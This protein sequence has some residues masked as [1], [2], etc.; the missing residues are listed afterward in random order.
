MAAGVFVSTFVYNIYFLNLPVQGQALRMSDYFRGT[1]GQHLLGLTGGAIW[2][3]G[4][5]A[6]LVTESVPTPV[7]PGRLG[8]GLFQAAPL[9]SALWGLL[10][11]KEFRGTGP[12][13][14]GLLAGTLLLFACGVVLLT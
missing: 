10:V 3:V 4:T 9:V 7:Q 11:W 1:S 6:F 13:T 5:L 12:V 2:C 8:N 14:K